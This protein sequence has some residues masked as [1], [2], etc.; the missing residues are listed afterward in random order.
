MS[1]RRVN[2]VEEGKDRAGNKY[3]QREK[4]YKAS[5]TDVVLSSSGIKM[6]LSTYTFT[7]RL[8]G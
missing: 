4:V 5:G 1:R 6:F 8:E 2:E 3:L 7:Q